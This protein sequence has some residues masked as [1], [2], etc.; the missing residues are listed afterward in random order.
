[1][2]LGAVNLKTMLA[3]KLEALAVFGFVEDLALVG[4]VGSVGLN[5]GAATRYAITAI[6]ARDRGDI[7]SAYSRKDKAEEPGRAMMDI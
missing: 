2:R 3:G 7:L 1:M 4:L 6:R 5:S